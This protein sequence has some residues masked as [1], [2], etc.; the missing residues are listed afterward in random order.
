MQHPAY[1]LSERALAAAYNEG[2]PRPA[3]G[4]PQIT[5]SSGASLARLDLKPPDRKPAQTS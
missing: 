1:M 2:G 3:V 5:R 4:Q